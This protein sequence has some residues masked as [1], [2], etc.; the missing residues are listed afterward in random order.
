M[1][2]SKSRANP[3]FARRAKAHLQDGQILVT[4]LVT[5]VGKGATRLLRTL[6]TNLR[7]DYTGHVIGRE[8]RDVQQLWVLSTITPK[9]FTQLFEFDFR[10]QNILEQMKCF[11]VGLVSG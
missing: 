3:F 7:N 6:S 11:H 1:G 4:S 10:A 8:D 2:A 5:S 9:L